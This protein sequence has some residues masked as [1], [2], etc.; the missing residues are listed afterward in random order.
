MGEK[1]RDCHERRCVVTP[2]WQ[3]HLAR[4]LYMR[5][6][7]PAVAQ[8]FPAEQLKNWSSSVQTRLAAGAKG[9]T[10]FPAPRSCLWGGL[11]D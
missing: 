10:L 6:H 9:L 2:P 8:F 11:E 3:E 4:K 1:A 7:R 5:R